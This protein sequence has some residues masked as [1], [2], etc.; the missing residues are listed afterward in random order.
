MVK[1]NRTAG[2]DWQISVPLVSN[3]LI[4][5]SVTT[6]VLVTGMVMA[7]FLGF[8]FFAISEIDALLPMFFMI[9]IISFGLWVLMQLIMLLIFG[10]R[11]P[12]YFKVDEKAVRCD[13]KSTLAKSGNR[14]A[15]ILGLLSRNPGVAGSGMLAMSQESVQY[16]W[17]QIKYAKFYDKKQA[18]S[19]RNSWRELLVVFAT[20]ENYEKVKG[21]I[22]SKIKKIEKRKVNP[23]FL[24]MIRSLFVFMACLPIFKT[25]FPIEINLLVSIIILCFSLATVWL[26]PLFGYVVIFGVL[27]V[28][29]DIFIDGLRVYESSL[30]FIPAYSGFELLN[31]SD[32]I[33]LSLLSLG[34][35]YLFVMSLRAI[36]GYDESA[37]MMD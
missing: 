36:K 35:L 33:S 28:I 29:G 34:L 27:Y 10:N 26:I 11:M 9:G 7:I 5:K 24:F 12:M 3:N 13:L 6:F 32:W 23:I 21:Y 15:V 16:N 2:F 22:K 19:L 8:I 1:N 17:S 14:A 4:F 37:L 30:S 20:D 18:I 25:E 31:D